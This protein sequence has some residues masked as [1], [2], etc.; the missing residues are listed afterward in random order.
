MIIYYF[1]FFNLRVWYVDFRTINFIEVSNSFIGLL[2]GILNRKKLGSVLSIIVLILL[3]IIPYVK[4]IIRPLSIGKE[5]GW[6]DNVCLQSTRA[7]CGP[8][9]LATIFR[10]FKINKSETEIAKESYS[11]NSGTEIW[12]LLR[13]AKTHGLKYICVT[14]M[15]IKIIKPPAIIGVDLSSIGHF[16]TYLDKTNDTYIIGDPLDGQSELTEEQFNKRYR[17]LSG[18]DIEFY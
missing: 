4:P 18:F 12:Y 15:D 9:C 17:K 2:M 8:S 14:E 10:H 7:T 1:Q 3:L 16:I 5:R 13:Y 6:K 11:C